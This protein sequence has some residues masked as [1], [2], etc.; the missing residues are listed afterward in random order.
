M[1]YLDK[2]KDLFGAY[3]AAQS[4]RFDGA[5]ELTDEQAA[6]LV[7]RDGFVFIEEGP[8]PDIPGSTVT[9]TENAEAWDTWKAL[10]PDVLDEVKA[11][12]IA[13]SKVDLAAYL[14]A[15]PLVWTDGNPYTCTTEKQQQLTSKLLAATMAKMSM[16]PYTLTWNTSGGVCQEWTLDTLSA[17]A[18]AIDAYVTPLVTYQQTME[19][20]MR[21][22][23]TQAEL[24]AIVVDYD[25][26]GAAAQEALS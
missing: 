24:D 15:N 4:S 25:T 12:R 3:G 13:Q 9:L 14:E 11:G 19:V 26:V 18:F 20:A 22:A 8:D 21:E 23:Q 6:F 17:L 10:Q 2:E 5:Y 16:Q 1:L 7:S